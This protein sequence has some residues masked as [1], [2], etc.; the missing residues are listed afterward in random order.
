[1]DQKTGENKDDLRRTAENCALPGK[2]LFFRF[3]TLSGFAGMRLSKKLVMRN[4]RCYWAVEVV[5]NI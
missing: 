4:A 5:K 3:K 1:M 2:A